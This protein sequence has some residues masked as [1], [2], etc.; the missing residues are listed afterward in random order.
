MLYQDAVEWEVPSDYNM[1]ADAGVWKDW[2]DDKEYDMAEEEDAKKESAP[3]PSGKQRTPKKHRHNQAPENGTN[4]FELVP[5]VTGSRPTPMS[6]DLLPSPLPS[7]SPESPR[8][9]ASHTHIV[10]AAP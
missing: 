2:L 9:H 3:S 8:D 1:S 7:P 5:V 6:A 4:E 10:I